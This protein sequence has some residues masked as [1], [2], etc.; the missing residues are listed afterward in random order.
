VTGH[1][2]DWRP[3]AA[4][5]LS[6]SPLAAGARVSV[7]KVAG[8]FLREARAKLEAVGL[9]VAPIQVRWNQFARLLV[10]RQVPQ[11]GTKVA[12]GYEVQLAVADVAP[13][14]SGVRFDP[15]IWRRY[16]RP[17]DHANPR[18]RMYAD[19]TG[20]IIKKGMP[21][22]DVLRLLG[23]ADSSVSKDLDYQLGVVESRD[24][25]SAGCW[26]LHLEIDHGTVAKIS[27][28][29]IG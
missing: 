25:E 15:A 11:A 6:P 20:R 7:P 2:P 12:H 29:R 13:P 27:R 5:V 24:Y 28:R 1:N 9:A 3:T 19:V 4:R 26:Y 21:V 17:C 10:T 22:A 16:R 18:R 14:F 23:R 8:L